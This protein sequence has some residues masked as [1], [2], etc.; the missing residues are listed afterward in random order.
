MEEPMDLQAVLSSAAAK[1][2]EAEILEELKGKALDAAAEG[3]RSVLAAQPNHAGS[4]NL[5]GLVYLKQGHYQAAVDKLR[6]AV[7]L[8]NDNLQ[9]H[10]QYGQALLMLGR[11]QEA[12][13]AFENTVLC[14]PQAALPHKWLSDLYKSE[15]R[16]AE[17]S[18]AYGNWI[19]LDPQAR[20]VTAKE[21][22]KARP[23]RERDGFFEAYCQGQGID[24]G[25]GGDLLASNCMAWD[26]EDGDAEEMAGVPDGAYDFVYSS[27]NLEHMHDVD[28]S[29][30]NWWRILKRGG[31]LILFLPHRDLF[32]KRT[33]LPSSVHDHRHY[34]LPDRD[35][36]PD[37]IGVEPLIHRLLPDA[38]ILYI[39]TCD[40]GNS[41]DDPAVNPDREYSIEAVLQKC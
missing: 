24:I 17:A 4:N 19:E 34:F 35:D 23:R 41:V 1:Y 13:A 5:L 31:Y 20:P 25:W 32:E 6:L 7:A 37:T 11:K 26:F 27:H 33:R 39:K 18:A 2:R 30:S 3:C 15:K 40:A 14:L 36:P 9:F 29:L 16:M 12:I 21:T 38:E 8:A 22:S 10:W 28:K